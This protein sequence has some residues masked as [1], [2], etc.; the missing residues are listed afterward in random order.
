MEAGELHPPLSPL[1][2]TQITQ[3]HNTPYTLTH[4]YILTHAHTVTCLGTHVRT[5]LTLTYSYTPTLTRSDTQPAPALLHNSPTV[6]HSH[7]HTCSRAEMFTWTLRTPSHMLTP[8]L[9]SHIHTQVHTHLGKP[10]GV[11]G[12]S[13]S[14]PESPLPSG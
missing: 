9:L 6:S 1:S 3:A 11:R 5:K 4:M 12:P 7:L 10:P 14:F 8:D 13:A 2:H